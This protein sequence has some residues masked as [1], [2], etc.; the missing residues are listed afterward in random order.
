[1]KRTSCRR[2]CNAFAADGDYQT[3]IGGGWTRYATSLVRAERSRAWF[4]W[5]QILVINY[6]M[7]KSRDIDRSCDP[8][9]DFHR[10]AMLPAVSSSYILSLFRFFGQELLNSAYLKLNVA[11]YHTT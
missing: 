6:Y 4:D 10:P 1:M 3:I 7:I 5:V 8:F 11:V 9:C 2:A